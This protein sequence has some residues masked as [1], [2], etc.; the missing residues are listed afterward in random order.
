MELKSGA[1]VEFKKWREKII[2]QKRLAVLAAALEVA[3]WLNS[4]DDVEAAVEKLARCKTA[5]RIRLRELGYVAL[6]I[7]IFHKHG[8]AFRYYWNRYWRGEDF[9]LGIEL[10][11]SE[12]VADPYG[13]GD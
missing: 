8:D 9:A 1:E 5:N 3:G 2:G 10:T 7:S 6:V 12:Q 13:E 4:K 11:K